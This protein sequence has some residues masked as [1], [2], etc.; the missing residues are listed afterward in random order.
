MSKRKVVYQNWIVDLGFDPVLF[1]YNTSSGLESEVSEKIENAVRESLDKLD[2]AEK[3]LIIHYYFMG[4]T[5]ADISE[6]SNRE[7]FKLAALH[8]RAIKKLKKKL[9][10]FVKVN[11]G[12]ITD[13]NVSCPICDHEKKNELNELI[14]SRDKT[15]TWRPILKIFRDK[16]LINLRTP[17]III[18]HEKYHM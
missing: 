11:F 17:Q 10:Q 9:S 16:Y 2:E 6:K 5:Y 13:L 14:D 8:K 7:I 15:K 18:G 3:E 12:I 1:S 4:Q